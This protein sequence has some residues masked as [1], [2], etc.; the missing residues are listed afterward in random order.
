[1]CLLPSVPPGY[2]LDRAA[3][4]RWLDIPFR[5]SVRVVH[6]WFS[7]S[8]ET[9]YATACRDTEPAA[10]T[11]FSV[12]IRVFCHSRTSSFGFGHTILSLS[13]SVSNGFWS[14]FATFYSF[15]FNFLS[16]LHQFYSSLI[17][18][19]CVSFRSP[20]LIVD[21]SGSQL[22]AS[23]MTWSSITYSGGD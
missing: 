1:M 6:L 21:N 7:V 10:Y 16:K 22:R 19:F 4:Y 18:D 15:I 8:S 3:V 5:R 9:E 14:H 2:A 20:Y 12:N 23:T 13:N 11:R 17:R